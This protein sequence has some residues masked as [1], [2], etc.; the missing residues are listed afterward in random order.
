[1]KFGKELFVKNFTSNIDY[2]KQYDV[3]K[4]KYKL[5]PNKPTLNKLYH[6]LLKDGEIDENSSFLQFS[7]K[8][9]IRSDSGVSVITILTSAKPKYEDENGNIIEQ[10]FSCP[11]DCA[12]CPNDQK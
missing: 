9:K 7:I 4:K 12:Y 10:N 3:L 11:H 2:V 8:K 6:K 1:M 5:C